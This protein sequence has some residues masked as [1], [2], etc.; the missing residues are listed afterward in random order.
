MG[1]YHTVEQGECFSS[2]A[3]KYGFENYRAIYEHAENA[4]LKKQRANPNV[5]Y[6]EDMV[7]IPDNE[8]KEVDGETE[9]KHKFVLMREKVTFRIVLKGEDEKPF[10]NT[11]YE[12][13][14]EKTVYEGKTDGTGKIEQ[15]ISA[16]A[17]KGQIILYSNGADGGEV[18]G[19]LPLSFGHLDPV[20]E[21][22]GV[23]ERL[24]NLGFG[25]GKADG[26]IGEKT[27][28]ALLAFQK[29]Y[30]LPETGNPCSATMEKLR[31][32]HDWQ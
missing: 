29:K 18:V 30:D 21:T 4:E 22:T 32:A 20:H 25:C 26:V 13:T 15:E 31:Q 9:K 6:P 5:L 1:K 16:N 14:I 11:R 3:F 17:R 28:A 8:L 2:L 12:M 27:K 10:A 7:F 19:V 23:Q 24:N